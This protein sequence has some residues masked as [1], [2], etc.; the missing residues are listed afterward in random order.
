MNYTAH[1]TAVI[2]PGAT[3]G[4]GTAIWHNSHIREGAVVGSGCTLGHSV[5]VDSGAV[6][7]DCCKLQNNVNIYSGV[8]LEDHVF[9]GPSMTFTNV[10][11][12]RCLHPREP[13]GPYHLK[14]LVRRGASIGAH[15]VVICGV[16]IGRHALVGAGSVVTKV[17]PDHALM[18]GNPARRI[19]WACECG[20][21][22]DAGLAC[23]HCGRVYCRSEN[24]LYQVR[25]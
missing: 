3:V 24:G 16:T 14:T 11:I 7:G 8:T 18:A 2:D 12:P 10:K 1:E 21:R 25:E 9:C 15:A 17:V 5:Y 13:G 22:L 20:E 4:D 19:G 23:P 6:V